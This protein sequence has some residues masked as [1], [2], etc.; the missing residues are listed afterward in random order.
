VVWERFID[1]AEWPYP[2]EEAFKGATILLMLLACLMLWRR[3]SSKRRSVSFGS[4][5]CLLSLA[6]V[7]GMEF[8]AGRSAAVAVLIRLST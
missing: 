7:A 5:T 4:I 3:W 6:L 1:M 2:L 8:V